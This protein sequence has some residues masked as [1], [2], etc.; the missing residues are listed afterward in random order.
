MNA[1]SVEE[2]DAMTQDEQIYRQDRNMAAFGV[3]AGCLTTV[4]GIVVQLR[5]SESSIG[6]LGVIG[7]LV[8]FQLVWRYRRLAALIELERQNS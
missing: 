7:M 4:L 5:D 8:T 6:F 1:V 2:K 3:A